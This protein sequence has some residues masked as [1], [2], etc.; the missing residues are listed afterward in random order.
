MVMTSCGFFFSV[1]KKY[2]FSASQRSRNTFKIC[3]QRQLL[4][5]DR[6]A[7]RRDEGR[8][9]GQFRWLLSE[10]EGCMGY[11]ERIRSLENL[12][13]KNVLT[14]LWYRRCHFVLVNSS[15]KQPIRRINLAVLSIWNKQSAV[16]RLGLLR[17]RGIT[18]FS[19]IHLPGRILDCMTQF[20]VS[21]LGLMWHKEHQDPRMRTTKGYWVWCIYYQEYV[22]PNLFPLFPSKS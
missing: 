20:P 3:Y 1:V 6:R 4:M 17:L 14:S 11:T 13:H 7:E 18:W 2:G 15:Q 10:W 21:H 16:Q 5:G 22:I 12:Y 8:A 19:E 9:W